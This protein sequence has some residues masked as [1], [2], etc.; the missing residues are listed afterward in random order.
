MG[1]FKKRRPRDA[2]PIVFATRAEAEAAKAKQAAAG[3][4]PGYG[5]LRN[6]SGTYY[7][8]RGSDTEKAKQYLRDEINVTREL[9][10]YVVETPNGNWGKDI[11]GLYLENLLPWQRNVAA[12]EQQGDIV[13]VMTGTT[14]F[15]AIDNGSTDNFIVCVRCGNCRHEWEDGVR[16]RDATA[17]R[18]PSCATL[19]SVDSRGISYRR[20]GDG[21]VTS[22]DIR[23]DGTI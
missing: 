8:F 21:V 9:T 23:P 15:V 7:V 1:W 12:A 14:G 3:L 4:E 17:V 11:D 6:A 20:F 5:I 19:N 2:G 13:G 10:Y 18:C 22:Y 16:Y